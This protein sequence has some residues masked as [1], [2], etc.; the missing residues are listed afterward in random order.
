MM[1]RFIIVDFISRLV[2]TEHLIQRRRSIF[3]I[4]SKRKAHWCEHTGVP[5]QGKNLNHPQLSPF[6]LA[7]P[8][9]CQP[10][11]ASW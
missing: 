3:L 11:R 10:S 9:S 4:F 6:P 8:I 7:R 2:P 1:E 5:L